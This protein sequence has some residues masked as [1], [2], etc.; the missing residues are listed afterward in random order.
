MFEIIFVLSAPLLGGMLQGIERQLRAR[1]QNRMGP[2][3]LQPFYD[4]FKLIEKRPMIVD[5][6]HTVFAIM[7]FLTLWAV[8]AM[9]VLGDNLLYVI[10]LHLLATIFLVIAGYSVKSVYSHLGANRELWVLAVYEPV[11]IL[12]AV[13]FYL[14][15][16]S[17]SL[18]SIYS[19]QAHLFALLPLFA[20]MVL[21]A[22]IKLGKSPFDAAHAHQE[23]I[24]GVEIEYGG[25]FYEFLYMAKWVEYIFIYTLFWLFAGSNLLLGIVLLAGV[26]VL[27]NLI[28]NATARIKIS[29]LL[30]VGLIWG[31]GLAFINIVGLLYV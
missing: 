3:L 9:L 27:L 4:M 10:F 11:L 26:F 14:L 20:A 1:M 6:A 19:G 25:V 12:F 16:G 15:E 5:E 28:D 30:K 8:V 18:Q 21:V 29:D 17:F 31:V 7:H 23:I 2:P 13:A 22:L 24:G